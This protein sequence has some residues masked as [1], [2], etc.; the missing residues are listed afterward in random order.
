M[1]LFTLEAAAG[2]TVIAGSE[3]A[4]SARLGRRAAARRPAGGCAAG[5]DGIP[6]RVTDVEY[7]GAD[8]VVACAVGS[9]SLTARVPGKAALKPG[10]AV[11]LAWRA[12]T[13]HFFDAASGRRRDDVA[14]HAIDDTNNF[15]RLV[16]LRE[17]KTCVTRR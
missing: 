9:Q 5:G 16:S 2:G 10:D 4:R 3:R 7:L 14:A 6:A 1:N 13:M 15:V 17:E 12:D 8:T 11:H